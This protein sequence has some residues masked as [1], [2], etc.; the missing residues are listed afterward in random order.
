MPELDPLIDGFSH[1]VEMRR[2]DEALTTLKKVASLVKPIMRQRGWRVGTLAEFYPPEKNL[3]GMLFDD[4]HLPNADVKVS[5]GITGRR[6]AC[7][8]GI[9]ET[10][11]SSCRWKKSLTRCFTSRYHG[12]LMFQV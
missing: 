8:C 11:G 2:G 3:L 1:L 9:L 12:S 5:T 7:V 10:I 6:Y 4:E